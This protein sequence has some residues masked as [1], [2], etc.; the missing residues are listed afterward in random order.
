[1]N[2]LNDAYID[3]L[4]AVECVD[5]TFPARS[6]AL[7]FAAAKGST[8]WDVEGKAY[9]DFCA[10]FG[11]LAL[12]H[13]PPEI[14]A[15]FASRCKKEERPPI[16]HG[17]GDV[18][19]SKAKIELLEYLISLLPAPLS[20][21][22]LALSG[23]QAVEIAVKSALLRTKKS[24]IICFEGSYHGL[25]LGILPLTSRRDFRA[26]FVGWQD[27]HA[28][29]RLP[30]LCDKAALEHAIKDLEKKG[31]GGAAIIVEP[32]QGR[33]GVK[34]AGNE[35][36]SLLREV[37]DEHGMLLIYDEIFTGLGRTGRVTFSK[38]VPCDLLCLGKALGGGLPL[39]ACVGTADAMSGW[40]KSRGEAIH[41][42]TFFGHPLA[43]ETG[44]ACLQ[45]IVKNDLVRRS[46]ELGLLGLEQIKTALQK[47]PA[48][49]ARVAAVR[50]FGLMTAVEF[51]EAGLGAKVMD[52]L[53]AKGV[54]A[55]ASGTRGESIAFTPA[56]NIPESY[57]QKLGTLLSELQL[58]S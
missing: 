2:N 5:S 50:G 8:I 42:G 39:S 24:G 17:M 4:M 22:A 29:R 49:Q 36:L 28:V 13:N 27:D 3:R 30:F 19:P 12:G 34:P 41:T 45:A 25:D 37:C 18:Y 26:P 54:I 38:E 1:M 51:K 55:L 48:L 43:C 56:L 40:P 46:R 35:W 52:L 7:V 20:I 15:V 14:N 32:V 6:P 21:A 16:S 23:G 53:R 11:V 57:W 31:C 33:A 58:P 9:L 47:T 44:L 10:G